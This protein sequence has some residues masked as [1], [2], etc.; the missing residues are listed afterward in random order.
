MVMAKSASAPTKPVPLGSAPPQSAMT[1]RKRNWA[2]NLFDEHQLMKMAY[3]AGDG[4]TL[5]EIG[6]LM[7]STPDRVRHALNAYGVKVMPR[8]YGS[9]HVAT[10]YPKDVIAALDEEAS[11]RRIERKRL[12]ERIVT[13]VVTDRLIDAVLDD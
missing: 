4:L 2:S 8:P 11:R 9:Q 12:I 5:D 6:A 3:L 7:G 10:W 13:T 1:A